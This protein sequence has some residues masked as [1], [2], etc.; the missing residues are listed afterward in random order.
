[1]KY[2]LD[3]CSY[4]FQ[5]R[6]FSYPERVLDS[7]FDGL[8]M[9]G[10]LVETEE[11]GEEVTV[12]KVAGQ[13]Y[14]ADCDMPILEWLDSF[15]PDAA[16]FMVL[17]EGEKPI[18]EVEKKTL[19]IG[20]GPYLF[21]THLEV[22]PASRGKGLGL[23]AILEAIRAWGGCAEFVVINPSPLQ[24]ANEGDN[25]FAGQFEGVGYEVAR[26]K[27]VAH[28][29]RIGF[30]LIQAGGGEK[31]MVLSLKHKSPGIEDIVDVNA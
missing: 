29:E 31:F 11:D 26:E 10:A 30:S 25:D 18:A 22:L 4:S 19:S 14:V 13:V 17:F 23:I 20:L 9:R 27:L 24:F 28:Y 8:H 3:L 15:G 5:Y 7:A 21:L 12:A 6:G 2:K 1:M 16:E